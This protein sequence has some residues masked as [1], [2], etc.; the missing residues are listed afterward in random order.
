[1][2]QPTEEEWLQEIALLDQIELCLGL[3]NEKLVAKIRAGKFGKV[4]QEVLAEKE[5]ELE[6]DEK[7]E[8]ERPRKKRT[9]TKAKPA[10][11]GTGAGAGAGAGAKSA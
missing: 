4:L 5:R 11:R 10:A 8:E 2:T 1:M 7:E 3:M 9:T 6:E